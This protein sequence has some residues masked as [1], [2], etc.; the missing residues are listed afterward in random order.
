MFRKNTCIFIPASNERRTENLNGGIKMNL[1]VTDPE[2]M[3][4]FE[5]FA[6]EEVPNEEGQQLDDK[7]I[8]PRRCG[9]DPRRCQALAWSSKG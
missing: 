3:E 4:R 2:F 7:G 9:G 1:Y 6:F 5:H 8:I